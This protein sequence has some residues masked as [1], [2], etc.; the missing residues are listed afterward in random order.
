MRG[1]NRLLHRDVPLDALGAY[2][3]AFGFTLFAEACS[4]LPHAA[5][6]F[7]YEGFH[8][9]QLAGMPAPPPGL[10]L[11]LVLALCASSLS[12]CL[13]L[14]TRASGMATLLLWTY[15]WC[16]DSL[17]EKA[18]HTIA[19]V[20]LAVLL[21]APCANR[22]S[23]DRLR[24]LRRGLPDLPGTGTLYWQQLLRLQF[25]QVYFFSGVAKMMNPE[26]VNGGVFYNVMNGRLATPLGIFVSEV[27]SYL[28]ARA[29]GLFT[30]LFELSVGFLL[31]VP[32]TRP[33]AIAAAVC[34]HLG[35][36]AS[37]QIGS[38]GAHFVLALL[39]LMPSP[40]GA[41]DG[42]AAGLSF[43]RGRLS[44]LRARA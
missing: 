43:L 29:G 3:A 44:A 7:S 38:L 40:E 4:W 6:L 17:T 22:F 9:P 10:A 27:D 19:M 11:L 34:F 14:F 21:L 2:R 13:G 26:W 30:I 25:A 12:F 1:L 31:L 28:F 36:Q 5:E 8:I 23:L 32:A 33:F 41:R 37:L 39:L 20:V 42:L 18:A 35:I 16:L 24:R 15:L